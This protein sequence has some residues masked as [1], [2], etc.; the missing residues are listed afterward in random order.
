M[1]VHDWTIAEYKS[2]GDTQ[3]NYINKFS[4]EAFWYFDLNN[5][6]GIPKT[7]MLFQQLKASG[8]PTNRTD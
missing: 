4:I 8:Y 1:I 2:Q 5:E 7:K 6:S 3:N